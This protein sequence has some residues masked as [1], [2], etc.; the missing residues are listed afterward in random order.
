MDTSTPTDQPK[1]YTQF[2]PFNYGFGLLM[3]PVNPVWLE[4]GQRGCMDRG[5]HLLGTRERSF[6]SVGYIIA[7]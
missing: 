7:V 5:T 2:R 3:Y 6:L 4:W 1:K